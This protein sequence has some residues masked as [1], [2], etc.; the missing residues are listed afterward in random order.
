MGKNINAGPEKG[1]VSVPVWIYMCVKGVSQM[2]LLL[3]PTYRLSI[4]TPFSI[5]G[6]L[7]PVGRPGPQD[8][9][10]GEETTP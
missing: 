5:P 1:S 8:S 7:P 9:R 10:I 2:S 4:T 3:I 6:L